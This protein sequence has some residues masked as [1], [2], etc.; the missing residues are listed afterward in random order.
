MPRAGLNPAAV[1]AEAARLA[2]DDGYDQL[3][4]AALAGRLGVAIPSLYKHIDGL[5]GLRRLLAVQVVRELGQEI[6]RAVMGRSGPDAVSA[7]AVAY[8]R[9][10]LRHPGR[11]PALVAAPDPD[12][13]ALIAASEEVLSVIYAVL[14]GYG[15]EGTDAVDAARALRSALHGFVMLEIGGGF[16][17]PRE[18]VRSF[19][20]MVAGLEVAL[21]SWT[22][23][24]RPRNRRTAAVRTGGSR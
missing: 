21:A 20:A 5:T 23:P 24:E 14:R 16:G 4:L 19:E 2:D 18:L 9:Y 13:Q 10:A 12:D 11:Y 3:T 15:I 6:A 22:P 7:L 17:L 8:R 1:V